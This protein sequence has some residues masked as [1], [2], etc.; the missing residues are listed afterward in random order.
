MEF[1][2]QDPMFQDGYSIHEALLKACEGAQQ[3]GGAYAFVTAGGAKLLLEDNTFS[4]L[5]TK[6]SFKLIVG[7][8]EIT[9]EK[10]L[11][12]VSEI[13]NKYPNGLEVFAFHH[14]TK[15]SLF[16][17]K[18]SWF[19]NDHG[20][21]LV[22]GSGNLTEK[23]LRRNREAFSIIEVDRAKIEEIEDYWNSWLKIN[24]QFIKPIDDEEVLKKAREN[25]KVF[26]RLKDKRALS[27]LD[28]TT[29]DTTIHTPESQAQKDE[30][31]EE[32]IPQISESIEEEDLEAWRFDDS[33]RA[34]VAEIPNNN[35]R[36]K[37]A[38]FSK[39]TFENFFGAQAG[40]NGHYRMLLR[41]VSATG[42]IGETE[43]RPS[44]SVA[45][46][47]WRIELGA[48]AGLVYP[49]SDRPIGIFVRVST[50]D[51]LYVLAMPTDPF[52]N[53]VRQYLDT[54]IPVTTNNQMKR[55]ITSVNELRT[56]CTHLPIWH[57]SV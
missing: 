40:V 6:G 17:P 8:D 25:T 27:D 48:A 24:S 44:V 13:R 19:K 55:H 20:G 29:N 1:H 54:E 16:H 43:I 15:G 32:I 56:R 28:G 45:S 22:L 57:I 46:H 2:I 21:V 37:Q 34:L 30:D 50:R 9:S 33:D 31:S 7:I 53:E 11:E 35:V 49:R 41:N 52:Y 42:R 18:F 36:W 4:Q 5:I 14:N 47:N 10:A 39:Y 38:N 12:K 23:G 26:L 3:G 51:F